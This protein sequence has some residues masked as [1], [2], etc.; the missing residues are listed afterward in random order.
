VCID[1]RSELEEANVA[2]RHVAKIRSYFAVVE[3][4][5]SVI[6][7]TDLTG[8][9]DSKSDRDRARRMALDDLRSRLDSSSV[10]GGLIAP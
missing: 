2:N 3:P 6:Q 5:G 1:I 10:L 7:Q 8:R 4:G 9:G